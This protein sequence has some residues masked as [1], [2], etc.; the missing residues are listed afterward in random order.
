MATKLGNGA[1]HAIRRLTHTHA[2]DHTP[3]RELLQRFIE[4]RDEDAFGLLM[5]RYG[6]MVTGVGLR[7]LHNRQDA[8]DVCQATF[9]LLAKKANTTPWRNSAANWLYEVAYRVAQ[10]ALKA[11]RRRK[12]HE[13][14]RKPLPVPDAMAD[15]TLRELQSVLDEELTLL[16]KKYRIP[17]ILCCLEGKARDQ[18]AQC[19]DVPL[20]TVKS[21]LEEGRE[22][23]RRR[24]ARRGLPL[25]IALAGFTL[26]SERAHAAPPAT[27]IEATGQA[28]LQA[29]TGQINADV[30]ST[31]VLTLVKGGIQSM[32]L[33]KLKVT[34]AIVA[35]VAVIVAG[36]GL[37]GFRGLPEL[38]A[39]PP[40]PPAQPA[41]GGEAK[42][43]DPAPQTTF[44]GRVL[45][46]DN[47]PVP[48]AKVHL[49]NGTG[50]QTRRRPRSGPKPTRTAA[51]RLRRRATR[52]SCSSPRPA[53]APAGI[54]GT[55]A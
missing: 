43:A 31:N 17:L 3:D 35:V 45:G 24:L 36:A 15:V 11:A 9:L 32:L 5:R 44:S 46:P 41:V 8:E 42:L 52:E 14:N 53:S 39:Q 54:R 18:V 22:L 38:A 30:V 1:L 7:V 21:R 2:D 26:F 51:S 40:K 12:L 50:R 25:S 10:D 4:K 55:V 27:L 48:G 34:T 49:L 29:L 23:L 13:G 28:A 47:K 37:V 33:T 19:L 16:P 20:A 6:S